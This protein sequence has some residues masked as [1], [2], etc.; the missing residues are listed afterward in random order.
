[1]PRGAVVGGREHEADT[2]LAHA[3]SDLVRPEIDAR[4]GNLEHV[5]AAALAAR[6]TVTVLGDVAAGRGG[7]EGGGGGDVERAAAVTT[8]TAGVDQRPQ[9]DLDRHGEL[10]HH[11][12]R[13][14]DLV[15]GLALHAQGD[16]QPGDLRWRGF[17]FHHR[18]HH[19][20]HLGEAEI[21]AIDDLAD[22]ALN[23]HCAAGLRRRGVRRRGSCR[24][25]GGRSR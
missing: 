16:Q 13:R 23:V 1:M 22:S 14:G 12:G 9:A 24:A 3:G 7:Y 6:G 20:V 19:F 17:A 4:T 5:G 15:D 8:G 11:R 18:D 25:A 2:A 21:A 10:A